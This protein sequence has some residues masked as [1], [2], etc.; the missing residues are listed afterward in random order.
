MKSARILTILATACVLL[1]GTVFAGTPDDAAPALV[2]SL[3]KQLVAK[4]RTKVATVDFTDVQGRP[5]ELGR[6]LA[7]QLSVDMVTAVGI[8]VIDRAN[9]S[10]VMAEHKL[11]AEGL[12]NPDNARKLGQFAGVDAL[13]IGNLAALD[14]TFT[15][16]VKA[17]S[18]ETSEIVAAGR[19]RF[20]VTQD[21]MRQFTTA[22]SADSVIA[23]DGGGTGS[24]HALTKTADGIAS[25]RFGNLHVVLRNV[26]HAR[27]TPPNNG[28]WEIPVIRCSFE[29]RNHDLRSSVVV[30]ANGTKVDNDMYIAL[31]SYRGELNDSNGIRW[32]MPEG[33][34]RGISYVLACDGQIGLGNTRSA[35]QSNPMAVAEYVKRGRQCSFGFANEDTIKTPG[36]NWAGAFTIIPP[37]SVIRASVDFVPV[38]QGNQQSKV[39]IPKHFQFDM[40]L[41]IG[42]VPGSEPPE[43]AKDLRLEN[44]VF[45]KIVLP[46][47]AP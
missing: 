14:G 19:M 15:L 2:Q 22:I 36:M 41:V 38:G 40:E 10:A 28:G 44:L 45:D 42:T 9:L 47:T 4:Q 26:T 18:T 3:A 5:N 1:A 30:A 33:M 11:T 24:T 7:E 6:F 27:M 20:D 32:W 34:L 43:K 37:G 25:K 23:T 16:T 21:M 17:I 29:M 8:T 39:S 46:T 12:V 13:L 35:R 31:G